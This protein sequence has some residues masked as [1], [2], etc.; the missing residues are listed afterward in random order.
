MVCI[1][2]SLLWDNDLSSEFFEEFLAET[3]H[4]IK[5]SFASKPK[6]PNNRHSYFI[7]MWYGTREKMERIETRPEK[8]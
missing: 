1:D 8:L 6:P 4:I 3:P 2:D 7:H 5:L